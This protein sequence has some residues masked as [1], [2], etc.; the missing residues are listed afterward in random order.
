MVVFVPNQDPPSASNL[1][2]DEH[3]VSAPLLPKQ[4][5][6]VLEGQTAFLAKTS[7]QFQK[8]VSMERM[9]KTECLLQEEVLQRQR[10]FEK[11][12]RRR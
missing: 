5:P 10:S 7:E 1:G 9:F 11:T 4:V 12:H 6:Q 3:E 8:V 2:D